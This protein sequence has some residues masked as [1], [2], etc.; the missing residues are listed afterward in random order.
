[1]TLDA[2]ARAFG[3]LVLGERGQEARRGPS[4][5][6]GAGGEVWSDGLDSRQAQVVQ[7]QGETAGVDGIGGLH[8]ATPAHT[9]ASSS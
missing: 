5:L 1:M 6:V 4:L 9:V 2:P 8:A 7:R 3:Q